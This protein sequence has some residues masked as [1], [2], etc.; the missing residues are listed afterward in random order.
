MFRYTGSVQQFVVP[1][2][3]HCV[4][5]SA[6]GAQGGT[7]SRYSYAPG[8]K[9]AFMQSTFEV[10][11]GSVFDVYVGGRGFDTYG[12]WNGGGSGA[13]SSGR[14]AYGG[15][16]SDVRPSGGGLNTRLMVAAG[17]GGGSYSCSTGTGGEGGCAV[18]GM[19]S[20]D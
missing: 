2:G 16:A 11:P 18:G 4:S 19:G 12:G 7:P 6:Y 1:S 8:G 5:V 13:L 17:G 3:V 15:G 20:G 14:A 10:T 9:G